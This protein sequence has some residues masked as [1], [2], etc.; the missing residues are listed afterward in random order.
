[1]DPIQLQYREELLKFLSDKTG[2]MLLDFYTRKSGVSLDK[3]FVKKEV[4]DRILTYDIIIYK[5]AIFGKDK[6]W[7]KFP[8]I[9]VLHQVHPDKKLDSDT[10]ALV[11]IILEALI[12]KIKK[13]QDEGKTKEE[14]IKII[15]PGKLATHAIAEGNNETKIPNRQVDHVFLNINLD[16]ENKN[17]WCDVLQYIVTELVGLAGYVTGNLRKKIV[18]DFHLEFAIAGDPELKQFINNIID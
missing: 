12:I 16:L 7:K 10:D 1:M 9:K 6:N 5:I 15:F 13:Y 14:I 4:I 18:K 17:F 11:N 3:K 2:S 8:N